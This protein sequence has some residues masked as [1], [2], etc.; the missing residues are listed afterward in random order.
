M[1]TNDSWSAE[2]RIYC[3]VFQS[4]LCVCVTDSF[5]HPHWGPHLFCEE[6]FLYLGQVFSIKIQMCQLVVSSHKWV[7]EPCSEPRTTYTIWTK[8]F[9]GQFCVSAALTPQST[10]PKLGCVCHFF[11]EVS[12]PCVAHYTYIHI[13]IGC[14]HG[15]CSD[16][17]ILDLPCPSYNRTIYWQWTVLN[18][19]T[20]I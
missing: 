9:Q 17:S 15:S 19:N 2:F 1:L 7:V 6:Y 10:A 11:W 20:F 5:W 13:P 3:Y 4:D 18:H 12:V 8:W 16:Y 14:K